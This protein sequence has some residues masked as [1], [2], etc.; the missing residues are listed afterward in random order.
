MK[1]WLEAFA[2]R[3]QLSP[4]AKAELHRY[5]QEEASPTKAWVGRTVFDTRT[6]PVSLETLE[7]VHAPVEE[8]SMGKTHWSGTNR[9]RNHTLHPPPALKD[10]RND[11][12]PTELM[13]GF[14]EVPEPKDDNNFLRRYED[15]GQIG[16]GGMGEVR[17]ARDIALNRVV[18]VKIIREDMR[19]H[20][21]ALV[22]F[23][24]EAQIT[25]QLK[26]PGIVPVHELGHLPD[27]RIY[28]TMKEVKG[29]TLSKVIHSVHVDSREAGSWVESDGW[30]LRRLVEAFHKVC[31]AIAYAHSRNV[32]HRDIKADNVM[33]GDFGE[34]L[35]V[36]WGVAKVLGRPERVTDSDLS[37]TTDR[38]QHRILETQSGNLV[39]TLAYMAPEQ[40]LG[41]V[42]TLTPAADVFSLGGMLY[43]IL[44]G[45]PPYVGE[46]PAAMLH[47]AQQGQP[48]FPSLPNAQE[49]VSMGKTVLEIQA[50][51]DEDEQVE[52]HALWIPPELL[53]ICQKAMQHD[54]NDRYLDAAELAKSIAGWLD[55]SR[56]REHANKLVEEA[57]RLVPEIKKFRERAADKQEQAHSL[58]ETIEAYE[59]DTKKMP[60]WDLEQEA[61]QLLHEAA[62]RQAKYIQL[63]QGALTYAPDWEEA[64]H[65]LAQHY[66]QRHKESESRRD[67]NAAAQYAVFLQNHD[68]GRHF[69]QYLKGDGRFNLVTHPVP[70]TVDLYEYTEVNRR[71][72]SRFVL[73]LG[74]TPKQKLPLPMGSYLL[75]IR[76]EGYETVRYPIVVHRQED[77][78]G[79]APGEHETRS[80]WLPPKGSLSNNEVY[81]PAGWFWAGGDSQVEL[82]FPRQ[83]LWV[84][85]FT[86]QRFPTTNAE[87]IEFLND[88]VRQGRE[89][90]ALLYVPRERAS[91]E[92]VAG[93]MIYKRNERG[94]F[95]LGPDA[96]GDIWD[97]EWP[98][99]MVD[100][101]SAKAYA[102][103]LRETTGQPW[104][105]PTELEWEKAARGVDGRFFPWGDHFD[106]SWC[107][108]RD[109][110]IPGRLTPSVI[111]SYPVDESPYGVRGMA[112]NSRDW[113]IDKY[114]PE[115][116][117][118]NNQA[119]PAP[120]VAEEDPDIYRTFRGG[121]WLG[122]ASGVRLA[123]RHNAL[124]INRA[125]HLGIRPCRSLPVED[126]G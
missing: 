114:T 86:L 53:Q 29:Q 85:G 56:K 80:I 112:G 70:A 113:C 4:E 77:W 69:A 64:H 106:A 19:E 82:C 38:S 44:A 12:A 107:C 87:Y 72:E 115:G 40:A 17:R 88:L 71:L 9:K 75:Q 11:V 30:N 108:M 6:G 46:T 22:R 32:L 8:V 25:A 123:S 97:P 81:V 89:E 16:I 65:L 1:E 49:P 37:V 99:I 105:L 93:A 34:A 102:D 104:R 120:T 60:A 42:E 98:V 39:G 47:H 59:P 36:D 100:W 58:L 35:V 122:Q 118:R 117:I 79:V 119:L 96:D 31:E 78:D 94:F 74:K 76:A 43:E 33:V 26:H 95:Y 68:V 90:E 3:Y 23:V 13:P 63:L 109:S 111:D 73:C 62:L 24:E 116:H 61:E 7:P 50:V 20:P 52:W 27:D 84:E 124:A 125:S 28:F 48:H 101:W 91:T 92:R 5:M 21:A 51:T 15:L 10:S 54:P 45:R 126:K 83:K 67:R 57:K 18:A 66:Q 103:W 55:G 110:H 41:E 14:S 121:S 2:A